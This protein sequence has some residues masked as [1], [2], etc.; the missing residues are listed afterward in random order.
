ML[1]LLKHKDKPGN[2][3]T[4]ALCVARPVANWPLFS[5]SLLSQLSALR[6]P[7]CVAIAALQSSNGTEHHIVGGPAG[8][9]RGAEGRLDSGCQVASLVI[10]GPAVGHRTK[11][12]P[13]VRKTAVDDDTSETTRLRL[14]P[15]MFP[16]TMTSTWACLT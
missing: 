13:C 6:P 14:Q 16:V 12:T 10:G 8:I 9:H 4:L 7:A 2:R 15:L 11:N 1:L 5:T 3:S